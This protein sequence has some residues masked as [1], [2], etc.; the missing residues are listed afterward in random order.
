MPKRRLTKTTVEEAIYET[1]TKP[2]VERIRATEKLQDGRHEVDVILS[3]T[4]DDPRQTP[5]GAA[6]IG[7]LEA[8]GWVV[9]HRQGREYS[10]LIVSEPI[11]E[12]G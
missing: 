2:F 12:E 3:D 1:K 6:L 5:Y 8:S 11:A 9:H 7:H 10:R 4:F